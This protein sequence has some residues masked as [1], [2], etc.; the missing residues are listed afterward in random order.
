VALGVTLGLVLGKFAGITGAS[1]IALRAGIA[2]L[3]TDTRF[4]EI[5]AVSLLAGIGFTMSIFIAELGFA[6][7]P[8]LLVTA[9]TGVLAASL[10]SGVA[11]FAWL[12]VLGNER[13]HR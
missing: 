11:G 8:D 1:W 9:K 10:I 6:G 13:V 5:A 12:W 7:R 4:A 3:P 2:Q